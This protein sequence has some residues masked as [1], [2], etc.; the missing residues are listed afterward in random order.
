M[1]KLLVLLPIV[2]L[3][4]CSQNGDNPSKEIGTATI[5]GQIENPAG[6]TVS[7]TKGEDKYEAILD[8]EGKFSLSV[9]L[10]EPGYYYLRHGS[11]HAMMYLQAGNEMSLSLNTE[12]FDE[13]LQYNGLG[14]EENNYLISKYLLDEK[15]T[16]DIRSIIKMPE[17]SFLTEIKG[18]KKKLMANLKENIENSPNLNPDFV[19]VEKADI[20][21]NIANGLMDYPSYH[22]YLTKKEDFEVSDNYYDFLAKMDLNEEAYLQSREFKNFVTSLVRYKSNKIK[23]AD[24]SLKDAED[25]YVKAQ[26]QVLP[27]ISES[28]KIKD[29]AYFNMMNDQLYY[30]G[31][32][33]AEEVMTAFNENVKDEEYIAKVTES[34]ANWKKLAKGEEA[35]GFSYPNMEGQNVALS[36]FKGKYVY[37]DVWA[38]WCGP[39]RAELPHLEEL[40]EK[41]ASNKDIVFTSVSIDE[42]TDAW[43][44]MVTEKEMMGVQLLADNAWDSDICKDYMIK[45]IPR[46]ILVDR[47]GKIM[48]S[49]APRPSSDEIKEIMADMDA[50]TQTYT[51]MK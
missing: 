44:K 17:D 30:H 34:V 39:C 13:T 10:K 12:E 3:F 41:Y 24:E 51:S 1:K 14:A 50:K 40:Q 2:L 47:E 45:G 29:Y 6:E 27:G 32:D 18:I 38:T 35:P 37:I 15:L 43:R 26:L 36:D 9:N 46:F 28:Q 23:N 16:S 42:D 48:D 7:I 21:F 33:I 8:E 11:E 22:K 49:K 31:A 4:A 5:S 19:K 20:K 25:G